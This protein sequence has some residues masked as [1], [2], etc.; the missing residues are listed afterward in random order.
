MNVI[1]YTKDFFGIESPFSL[2]SSKHMGIGASDIFKDGGTKF[3]TAIKDGDRWDE[4]LI[5][6]KRFPSI[7]K[8]K[9][10]SYYSVNSEK[11]FNGEHAPIFCFEVESA[12]LVNKFFAT[13]NEEHDFCFYED[14]AV[15]RFF[16]KKHIGNKTPQFFCQPKRNSKGGGYIPCSITK[17][18]IFEVYEII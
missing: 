6:M 14:E 10:G 7:K 18:E 5:E 4:Y 13:F 9:R 3:Q 17:G 2:D 15:K 1:E 8:I 16:L 11:F 12:V